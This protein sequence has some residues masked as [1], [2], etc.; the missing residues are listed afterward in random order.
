MIG[1]EKYTNPMIF[2]PTGLRGILNAWIFFFKVSCFLRSVFKYSMTQ[3]SWIKTI[4]AALSAKIRQNMQDIKIKEKVVAIHVIHNFRWHNNT[5]ALLNIRYELILPPRE[6]ATRRRES[7]RE[8]EK[9]ERREREQNQLSNR[10]IFL[11]T[12]DR[13]TEV[14]TVLLYS[15]FNF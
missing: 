14:A 7:S 1:I 6:T 12:D 4:N 3:S 5:V 8:R 2:C 11:F 13:D 10:Y 15:V 9:R